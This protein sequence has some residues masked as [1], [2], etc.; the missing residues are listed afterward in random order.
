MLEFHV[1]GTQRAASGIHI[2]SDAFRKRHAVFLH[3][4][5]FTFSQIISAAKVSFFVDI[6]NSL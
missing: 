6:D 3:L 4:S 2:L 1:V 5:F